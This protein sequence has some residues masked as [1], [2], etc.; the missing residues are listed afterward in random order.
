MGLSGIKKTLKDPWHLVIAL[1]QRGL[2]DHVS[3]KTFLKLNYRARMGKKLD[4]KNPQTFTE[5]LQWLKLYD[6]KPIYTTMVDKCGLKEYAAKVIGKEHII[7][8]YGVWDS[9][10]EIDFDSLPNKFV[11]KTTHDSGGVVLC[12]DKSTMFFASKVKEDIGI[13]GV[14]NILEGSLKNNYFYSSREWPYKNVKPR[15]IAERFLEEDSGVEAIDYKVMCFNGEPKLV[16]LHL[17]RF[18]KHTQDFYDT[19]WNKL[20]ME[21]D[22]DMSDVVLD[23][24]EWLDELLELSRKMAE[25]LPHI[26][27]DWYRIGGV[28]YIGEMTF[29]DDSGYGEFKPEKWNDILGNWITLPEKTEEK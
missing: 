25:G 21:Y 1:A 17:G 27:C 2:L 16:Q 11:L 19:N 13:E 20:D 5:K 14:R 22:M 7:E 24:P 26:R 18:T 4:L 15:I 10:D 8:T 29:F 23:R 6:R 12:R 3:D 9:F 28:F